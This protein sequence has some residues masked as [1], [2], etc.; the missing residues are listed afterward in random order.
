MKKGKIWID[1]NPFIQ[2]LVG[3]IGY[4]DIYCKFEFAIVDTK[5]EGKK[6]ELAG[7]PKYVRVTVK[8]TQALVQGLRNA[9]T[10]AQEKIDPKNLLIRIAQAEA[11]GYMM[12]HTNTV[13]ESEEIELNYKDLYWLLRQ[14]LDISKHE[15][16][17]HIYPNSNLRNE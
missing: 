17:F 9:L 15:K 8:M 11:K 4:T 5:I 2:E 13:K 10:K 16:R 3:K 12:M 14:Y 1:N 6:R 7:S